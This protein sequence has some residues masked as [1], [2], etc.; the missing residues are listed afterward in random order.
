ME[1]QRRAT[2]IGKISFDNGADSGEA[3]RKRRGV[4]DRRI[5][6]KPTQPLSTATR[7]AN[8]VTET[9]RVKIR[10]SPQRSYHEFMSFD[11]AGPATI[12][13]DDLHNIYAIKKLK[14]DPD[15]RRR[16]AQLFEHSS[17]VAIKDIFWRSDEIHVVH[18]CMDVSLQHVLATPMGHL[19]SSEIAVICKQVRY[20][21]ASVPQC[22]CI[23][24]PERSF[25][26]AQQ[27]RTFSW[28]P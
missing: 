26:S 14:C 1:V 20:S 9:R 7:N 4:L 18:E 21:T 19:A 24:G 12:A 17:L 15:K 2:Q 8:H 16:E 22:S 28:S 5:P 3:H 25:L 6:V 11:Q 13:Y 10:D 23:K 27:A